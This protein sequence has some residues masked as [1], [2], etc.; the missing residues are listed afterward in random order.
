M[1][2]KTLI[3]IDG[4]MFILD[5]DNIKYTTFDMVENNNKLKTSQVDRQINK[6]LFSPQ[7]L[8]VYEREEL[9]I[10]CFYRQVNMNTL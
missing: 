9:L 2:D 7:D 3:K 5:A 10:S 6:L 8:S 4:K 1:I